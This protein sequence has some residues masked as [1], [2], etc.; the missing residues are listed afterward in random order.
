M[1]RERTEY[2]AMFLPRVLREAVALH[3]GVTPEIVHARKNP[4]P[5]AAS[6]SGASLGTWLV[7]HRRGLTLGIGLG[8]ALLIVLGTPGA[9]RALRSVF[10]AL[11][12]TVGVLLVLLAAISPIAELRYNELVLVWLPTDLLL[13]V[14]SRRTIILYTS[15]RLAGLATVGFLFAWGWFLQPLWPFWTL[16]ALVLGAIWARTL[17]RSDGATLE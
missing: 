1:D 7:T 15:F 6:W 8:S 10:G 16:A 11:F 14:D 13:I 12:G 3:L 9:S 2:E 4:A 5:A 17:V